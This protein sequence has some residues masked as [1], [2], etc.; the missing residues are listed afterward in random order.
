M[1]LA[2]IAFM[3]ATSLPC[4]C[5]DKEFTFFL[6]LWIPRQ[7]DDDVGLCVAGADVAGGRLVEVLS[8]VSCSDPSGFGVVVSGF[9]TNVS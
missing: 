3:A 6:N 7:A 9:V 1:P 8:S 2:I 4:S 5:L